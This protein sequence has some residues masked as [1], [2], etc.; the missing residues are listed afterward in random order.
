MLC[1]FVTSI[2]TS[3][4]FLKQKNQKFKTVETQLKY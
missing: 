1:S 4:G 3:L 2:T